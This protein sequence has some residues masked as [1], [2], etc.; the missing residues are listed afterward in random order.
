MYSPPKDNICNEYHV[1][2]Y[3]NGY[4]DRKNGIEYRADELY[5][6]SGHE[7]DTSFSDRLNF[8]YYQ[9]YYDYEDDK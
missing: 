6:P 7:R 2:A 9:G 5:K 8:A 1:E 4:N 3:D